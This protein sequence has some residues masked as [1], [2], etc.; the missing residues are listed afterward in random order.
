MSDYLE[1]VGNF[2]GMSDQ[3]F[4]LFMTIMSIV[5]TV[6]VG[7]LVIWI[8]PY[9]KIVNSSD[10]ISSFSSIIGILYAI[11]LGY[12]LVTVYG[13]FCD[14]EAVVEKEVTILI[15]LLRE[16]EGLPK[17]EAKKIHQA[18]ME[19]ISSVIDEEWNHMIDTGKYHPNTL[20]KFSIVY[21][22]ATNIK[23]QSSEQ[24]VFLK[25]VADALSSL[26]TARFERVSFASSRVP[27]ILWEL[28]LG[29]GLV[30]FGMAFFFP[31]EST[32]LRLALLCSTAGV[33]TF[34]TLL[35]YMLDRPYNGSLNVKPESLIR[36]RDVEDEVG[37]KL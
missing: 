21:K 20:E 30:S 33:M 10:G 9:E 22:I 18:T 28:L 26:S 4:C 13:N 34:T 17:E 29:V 25:E 1:M 37:G 14:T 12:V 11:I 31:V 24:L 15:E 16:A 32:R 23:C 19:Y 2:L 8:F 7:L 36:V 5:L 3:V 35:I 6:P 27:D